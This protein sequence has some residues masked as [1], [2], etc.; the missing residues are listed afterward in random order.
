MTV[1]LVGAGPGD[2]ELLT[3]RAARLLG[4]AE[5]VVHDRLIGDGILAYGSPSAERYDVGKVPGRPGPS[6]GEINELLVSLGQRLD[7]VVRLKGGDPFVFGRGAEEAEALGRAGIAVEITPGVTSALAGPAAA[8]ISVTRRAVSSGV[9]VVTA[10]QGATSAPIDWAALARSGLT[11]V[12]L[13]GARRAAAVRDQLLAAGM[14]PATAAATVTDA[15]LDHQTVWTGR[16]DQLG[17]EPVRSP[18]VLVVGP[19]AAEA[20]QVSR[21]AAASGDRPTRAPARA[22]RG[23]ARARRSGTGAA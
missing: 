7:C 3:L 1:H 13:M 9:C 5:A 6:Q 18:S 8:G 15:T 20:L 14:A 23:P 22:G 17:V 4:R 21:A 11:L 12:V 19:A 2:P 10:Q 16:L